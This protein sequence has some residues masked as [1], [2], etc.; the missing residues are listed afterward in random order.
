MSL[1]FN[2][3]QSHCHALHFSLT[4][5]FAVGAVLCSSQV[6][7]LPTLSCLAVSS[8]FILGLPQDA[9]CGSSSSVAWIPALASSW[10]P[11]SSVDLSHPICTMLRFI[12]LC[13]VDLN[14]WFLPLDQVLMTFQALCDLTNIVALIQLMPRLSKLLFPQTSF[15]PFNMAPGLS[16]WTYPTISS[17]LHV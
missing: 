13:Q 10:Y 6:K 14:M 15:K 7:N 2:F 17:F 3:P 5:W 16:V 12:T 8:Y 1:Y 11:A 4:E 9:F